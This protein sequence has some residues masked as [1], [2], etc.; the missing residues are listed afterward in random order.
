MG[1][2]SSESV[3]L[4]DVGRHVWAFAFS[5]FLVEVA[6]LRDCMSFCAPSCISPDTSSSHGFA[7]VSY[8][9]VHSC[10]SVYSHV[11]PFLLSSFC[12]SR[13]R[14]P[15]PRLQRWRRG[16]CCCTT[17]ATAGS[18]RR[19]RWPFLHLLDVCDTINELTVQLQY[20]YFIIIF[21]SRTTTF[22]AHNG[23]FH[24]QAGTPQ[25][26]R[27]ARKSHTS[28]ARLRRQSV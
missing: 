7:R 1:R 21:T 23:R 13:R 20:Q 22:A 25:A 17:T 15:P 27:C 12:S 8:Y 24:F 16:S 2:T 18:R 10:H 4:T 6:P 9:L 28:A 19:L 14:R 3:S 5:R 26:A 11:P